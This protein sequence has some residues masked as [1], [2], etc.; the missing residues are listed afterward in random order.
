LLH[1][2]FPSPNDTPSGAAS[3]AIPPSPESAMAPTAEEGAFSPFKSPASYSS[4]PSPRKLHPLVD[5]HVDRG[6]FEE[7]ER[8]VERNGPW[9]DWSM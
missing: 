5:M 8:R 3:S 9:D 7:L 1:I 2:P 6:A 4:D